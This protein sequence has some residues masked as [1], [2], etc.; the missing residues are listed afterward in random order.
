MR[1]IKNAD[2][3]SLNSKLETVQL[4]LAVIS[5]QLRQVPDHEIRLRAM[6]RWRYGLPLAGLLSAA[7]MAVAAYGWLR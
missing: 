5:E 4:Q 6:E 3:N 7:S 1:I 2:A